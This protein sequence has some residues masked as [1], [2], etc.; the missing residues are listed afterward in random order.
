MLMNLFL[1]LLCFTKSPIMT[2]HQQ[3]QQQQQQEKDDTEHSEHMTTYLD[4]EST[5]YNDPESA[6]AISDPGKESSNKIQDPFVKSPEKKKLVRKIKLTLMPCVT[7]LCMLQVADT[8][9]HR[10][11]SPCC[12]HASCSLQINLL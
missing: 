3:Q 11:S 10:V 5:T 6:K 8:L 1:F 2:K 4:N 7:F 9:L 12:L